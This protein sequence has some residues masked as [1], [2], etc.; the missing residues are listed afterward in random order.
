MDITIS[1]SKLIGRVE[2][3]SSKSYSHRAV[4]AAALAKGVSEVSGVTSSKDI[5]VTCAA[6]EALGANIIP[7]G[8]V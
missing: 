2:I 1:P 3:P 4:I 6:M 8:G 7:D 5:E